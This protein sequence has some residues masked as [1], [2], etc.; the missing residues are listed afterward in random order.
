MF[1]DNF[2]RLDVPLDGSDVLA[3]GNVYDKNTQPQQGIITNSTSYSIL[4]QEFVT[5]SQV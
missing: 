3:D 5:N 2:G 4:K 1:R